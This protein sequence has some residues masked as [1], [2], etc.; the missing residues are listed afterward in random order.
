MSGTCWVAASG[1]V[2]AAAH[3]DWL[4]LQVPTASVVVKVGTTMNGYVTA[5]A[6]TVTVGGVLRGGVISDRLVLQFG[7]S[8]R[9]E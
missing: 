8:I 2:G 4:Q 6:G 7:A 5:P 1:T 3:P 9:D